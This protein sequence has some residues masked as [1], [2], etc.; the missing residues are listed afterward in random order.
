MITFRHLHHL[1]HLFYFGELLIYSPKDKPSKNAF[2]LD[3]YSLTTGVYFKNPNAYQEIQYDFFKITYPISE[4]ENSINFVAEYQPTDIIEWT[5]ALG[6]SGLSFC[7]EEL[8][9]NIISLFKDKREFKLE[10]S[11]I[12]ANLAVLSLKKILEDYKDEKEVLEVVK[13]I[14]KINESACISNIVKIESDWNTINEINTNV[15]RKWNKLKKVRIDRTCFC[16]SGK[17]YHECCY[18]HLRYFKFTKYYTP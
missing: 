15:K 17:K 18:H 14:I 11:K 2:D 16:K 6:V 1:K 8:R 5:I 3:E 10:N 13:R 12:T 4:N 9:Y 7:S